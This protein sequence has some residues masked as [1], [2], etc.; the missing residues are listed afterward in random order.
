MASCRSLPYCSDNDYGWRPPHTFIIGATLLAF[1]FLTSRKGGFYL[2]LLMFWLGSWAAITQAGYLFLGGLTGQGDPGV[3]HL[4]TG[5]PLSFFVF[6]G[7]ILFLLAYFAVSVLF[8]SEVAGLFPEYGQRTLLFEFW[9]TVPIQIIFLVA[10]PE[11]TMSFGQ[12]IAFLSISMVPSLLSILFFPFIQSAKLKAKKWKE[13]QKLKR[14]N[15][16]LA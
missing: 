9:L 6:L 16:A 11:H 12:F 7:F 5:V 2:R 13:R 4:L 15:G 8:L 10:S 14:E 1:L 3:L